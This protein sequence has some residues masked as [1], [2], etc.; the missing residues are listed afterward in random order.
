MLKSMRKNMKFM[1]WILLAS[2]VLWGGSS[3]VL[4]R[5]KTANYAGEVFGKKAGW[6]E[7]EQNYMA[8]YNQA[9]LM[10]GE[11][12]NQ[13]SQYLNIEQEAWMRLILIREAKM[14][15]IK[16]TDNEV[17]AAVCNIPLFQDS[18]GRFDPGIY[19]RVV[20]YF[21]KV[22]PREFEEEIKGSIMITK[23]KDNVIKDVKLSDQELF[24][25]YKAKNEKINADYALVNADDFKNQA[26]VTDEKI[27]SYYN[28]YKESFK[29]PLR[30][31]IEYM[32]FEYDKYKT[33]D[34][35]EN[36]A[37]DAAYEFGQEKQPNMYIIA[38]KFNIPVKETGFFAMNEPASGIGLSKEI[39]YEAF[40]LEIGQVSN[41]IK[42]D[43]GRYIIKLKDKKEP[44]V[45]ALGEIKD[46]LKD[47]VTQM[48]AA[49][50]ALQKAN[51]L[52]ATIKQKIAA[53]AKFKDAC[54]EL[55]LEVKSTG[56]F[57]RSGKI[58]GIANTDEFASVA[59]SA[60]AG[61]LAGVARIP[62]STAIVFVTEKTAVD[63]ET[64]KKEKGE[65]AKTALQEKQAR[66]FEGWFKDLTQ[67][68][69][70][71]VSGTERPKQQQQAPVSMP[72]NDF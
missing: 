15:H 13:I 35:A 10:Y 63:E 72:L 47:V 5:S 7:Y 26:A 62:G 56:L 49:K 27:M 64:F 43:K 14:R 9:R 33:K 59:F 2:F 12:F 6:K 1:L 45:P 3:A 28:N 30:V 65:F 36:A 42:T 39:A 21:L 61:K 37:S 60:E 69:A 57:T 8:V 23:L 17:I 71:K 19:G 55:K 68:A 22:P 70:L 67:K 18:N 53:G 20:E 4:S 32:A 41:P 52:S 25:A 34:D 38:K 31:N 44:A 51:E 46:R 66:Y 48:E 29:T 16:A 11:K 50:L 40:K 54:V 24:E 58:P